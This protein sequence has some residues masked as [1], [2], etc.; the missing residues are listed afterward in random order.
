MSTQSNTGILSAARGSFIITPMPNSQVMETDVLILGAGPAGISTALHL[1]RVHQGWARRLV[2]LEKAA[3]PRPKLCGGGLTRLGLGVLGNLDLP[4]PLP[5]PQAQVEDV[6]IVYR[7]R[8]VHL[9]GRPQFTVFHRPELDAWLASEARRRGVEIRENEPALDLSVDEHGVSVTTPRCL[10]RARVVVGA[11][12]SK[13]L[14]RRVF[15]RIEGQRCVARL[16]EVISPA[17]E[18]ADV[19]AGRFALFDFS[20]AANALQGYTWKFPARIGGKPVYN[21]GVYDARLADARPRA[22]LPATLRGSHPVFGEEPAARLQGHPIHWFHPRALFSMPR[23]LL[24]G[25]AA[26]A[27]A[28]FG[29]GIAPAF[30]YGQVAAQAICRAFERGDFSFRDYRRL[31]LAS[32]VGRY[33]GLRWAIA[34]ASY[35]MSGQAWFMHGAWTLGAWLARL[36]PAPREMYS[37]RKL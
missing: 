2:V 30:G 23:L 35:H 11:D 12:G 27:D 7:G 20:A 34:Q 16:L 3:H 37:S 15:A 31:V 22:D 4:L 19:F 25:D 1:L 5:V 33:L 13:G 36:F 24:A 10:Y 8:T 14:T 18:E 6:R 29:E 28:L 32:P 26:G 9:H 21:L 17:T